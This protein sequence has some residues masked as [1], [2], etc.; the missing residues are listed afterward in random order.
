MGVL[1][2]LGWGR[3]PWGGAAWA[4]AAAVAVATAGIVVL[5]GT[6][7]PGDREGAVGS[8]ELTPRSALFGQPLRA[9]LQVPT[10]NGRA[11]ASFAPYRVVRRS[12]QR[13]GGALRITYALDCLAAACTPRPGG[14]RLFT[15]PPARVTFG[16]RTYVAQW[17]KVSV[18]SRLG[19]APL[20]RPALRTPATPPAP[21]L[22][23]DPPLAADALDG[24]AAALALSAAVVVARAVRRARRP[25]PVPEPIPESPLARALTAVEQAAARGVRARR[26]ALDQLAV[27]LERA[28][29]SAAARQARLLAWSEDEP[30]PYAMRALAEEQRAAAGGGED[31]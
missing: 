9:V 27:V 1:S 3:G 20:S 14:E 8:L 5:L 19:P 21:S 12:E 15:F 22:R 25:V 31:V 29:M 11:V 23:F 10:R 28:H 2:R 26:T 7:S 4:A 24:L 17:P 18:A 6:L 16:G 30:S 13:T